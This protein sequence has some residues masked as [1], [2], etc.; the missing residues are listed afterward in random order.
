[1]SV[2]H[3]VRQGECLSSI[4]DRFGFRD[5]RTIYDDPANAL[6]RQ[7]RPDPNVLSPGDRVEIPDKQARAEPAATGVRH[8][9]FA[10]VVPTFLRLELETA[11]SLTYELRVDG[12]VVDRGV[13]DGKDVIVHPIEADARSAQITIWPSNMPSKTPASGS[14]ID[15]TLGALDPIDTIAGVQGRLKN[16]SFYHGPIDDRLNDATIEAIRAFEAF[17]GQPPTG[18]V[19]DALRAALVARH[20]R[21]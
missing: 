1:M 21:P 17:V 8:A 10:R 6:L 13:T 4:A 7:A 19:S 3:V 5:Y 2:V 15:L 18:Q 20:D 9:F 16:L 14:T 11:R 12:R